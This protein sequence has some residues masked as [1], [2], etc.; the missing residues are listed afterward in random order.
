[1]D[2]L[3]TFLDSFNRLDSASLNLLETIYHPDICFTDPAHT[4]EGLPALE[5]YFAS[6][7]ENVRSI[8]FI[9]DTRVM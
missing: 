2:L 7:Y 4:L 5:Q 6:L 1:M 8:R 9:F 3:D